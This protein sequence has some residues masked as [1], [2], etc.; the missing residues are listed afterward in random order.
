MQAL[1]RFF[2][3]KLC[4]YESNFWVSLLQYLDLFQIIVQVLIIDFLITRVTEFTEEDS[5]NYGQE[6]DDSYLRDFD[7]L[8]SSDK[9]FE[10]TLQTV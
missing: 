6:I 7:K 1:I 5:E 4:D 8:I 10:K 3:T 9:P 2:Y